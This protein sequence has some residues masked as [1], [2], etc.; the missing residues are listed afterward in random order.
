M[1]GAVLLSPPISTAQL[2]M[3]H[4]PL[5][6]RDAPARNSHENGAHRGTQPRCGAP[7]PD[8]DGG[9]GR[10]KS[11]RGPG[12]Q[13]D[14]IREDTTADARR[15]SWSS[16]SCVASSTPKR[17]ASHLPAPAQMI[18]MA[19]VIF[20]LWNVP[21]VRKLLNPLKLFT[22]G[23]HELFHIFLVRRARSRPRDE[24]RPDR[25]RRRSSVGGAYSR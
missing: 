15:R 14:P 25:T 2:C 13:D 16:T 1:P 20:G 11:D 7:A 17:A 24:R 18:S 5:S 19:V 9:R 6:T 10:G 4:A 23:L 12:A 3:P 22:I 21:I 8:V